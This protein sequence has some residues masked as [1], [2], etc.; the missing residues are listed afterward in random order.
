MWR[1]KTNVFIFSQKS[2]IWCYIKKLNPGVSGET[3]AN[4][5]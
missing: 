3:K 4:T 1:K 5:I 2:K